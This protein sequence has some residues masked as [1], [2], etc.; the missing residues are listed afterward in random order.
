MQLSGIEEEYAVKLRNY[1]PVGALL[2]GMECQHLR[3]LLY[4]EYLDSIGVLETGTAL[5]WIVYALT[6]LSLLLF[7]IAARKPRELDVSASPLISALGQL[8]GGL[9]LGWTALRYSGEMPGF[10]G[11]LWKILG[12]L[13]ALCLLWAAVCT[14]RKTQIQFLVLLIP[15]LF[16]LTHLIDNYR[17][18]S[19]QPQLQ[20]YLFALL[21]TMAMT[22]FSYYTA[23][24]A[25]GMGK[26]RMH[27]FTALCAGFLC[28]AAM[29]PGAEKTQLLFMTSA[30]WAVSGL[31]CE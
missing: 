4:S 10:L 20:S 25:V 13:S 2:L 19:G 12:I 29:L 15:C 23:A 9:G 22:L 16:W 28:L 8:I 24:E 5:E 27:T 21:G 1:L 18:W 6:A 30:L 7:A 3:R 14:L 31:Y 17:G 26:P 11:T